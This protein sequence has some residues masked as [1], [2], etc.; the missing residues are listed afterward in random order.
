MPRPK[1]PRDSEGNVIHTNIEQSEAMLPYEGELNE[2]E[3]DVYGELFAGLGTSSDEKVLLYRL[4]PETRKQALLCRLDPG[5][6]VEDIPPRFGGGDYIIKRLKSGMIMKQASLCVEGEPI[7]ERPKRAPEPEVERAQTDISNVL[8][9][10][11]TGMQEANRQLL[12]GLAQ[13]MRPPPQPTRADMLQ[14]MQLMKQMFTAPDTGRQDPT[15]ILMRGIELAK[16]IQPRDGDTSGMDVLQEAIRSFA[17]AVAEVVKRAHIAPHPRIQSQIKIPQGHNVPQGDNAPQG[18]NVPPPALPTQPTNLN[19]ADS[20]ILFKYYLGMLCQKAANNSDPALYAD[21]VADNLNDDQ[22]IELLNKPDIVAHLAA[23]NPDVA[24]HTA[25]FQTLE[26][27]LRAIV[28]LT[29]NSEG[30]NVPHN[31]VPITNN[32]TDIT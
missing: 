2:V 19:G 12:A 10:I 23:I 24:K 29:D 3:Q 22:L 8:Q 27:E 1:L 20:M 11:V 5:T 9:N 4:N 21:M 31:D 6:S 26:K 30:D 15:D 17:P 18:D 7:I 16:S 14:E 32:G 25:W 28:S 13:I